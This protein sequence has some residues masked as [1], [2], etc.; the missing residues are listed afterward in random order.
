MLF[1]WCH[2]RY[3]MAGTGCCWIASMGTRLHFLSCSPLWPHWYFQLT[4]EVPQQFTTASVYSIFAK[5]LI[6]SCRYAAISSS[7]SC[8]KTSIIT[9][10]SSNHSSYSSSSSSFHNSSSI[11]VSGSLYAIVL[12]W[13]SSASHRAY[14][15]TIFLSV[16]CRSRCKSLA[17]VILT[18]NRSNNSKFSVTRVQVITATWGTY[19]PS[20]LMPHS[21]DRETTI[22]FSRLA[23]T[24]SSNVTAAAKTSPQKIPSFDTIPNALTYSCP[25]I[26]VTS[27]TVQSWPTCN[28]MVQSCW[29]LLFQGRTP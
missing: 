11:I 4:P 6:S 22:R 10:L 18:W 7:S 1:V 8:S 13:R 28:Q 16:S 24:P 14:G 9:S 17:L 15:L 19:F 12:I 26:F 25:L 23:A 3:Q 2:N 5:D 27:R 21:W 20:G 29:A